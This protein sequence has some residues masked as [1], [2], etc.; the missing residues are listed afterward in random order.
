VSITFLV[1]VKF[2][3]IPQ[4]FTDQKRYYIKRN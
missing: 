1:F 2:S 4:R 3:S